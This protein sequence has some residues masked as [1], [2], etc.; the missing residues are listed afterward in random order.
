M[1]RSVATKSC[2]AQTKINAS[3]YSAP[4]TKLIH[5]IRRV[6][7]SQKAG[8][9]IGLGTDAAPYNTSKDETR[10]AALIYRPT[11]Y[12]ACTIPV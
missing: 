7:D 11:S 10:P 1:I 8:V 6:R 3:H 12:H 9:N 2:L 4:D 5:G